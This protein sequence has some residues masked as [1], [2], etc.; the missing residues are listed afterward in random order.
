MRV[1][2]LS[3]LTM[4]STPLR[5]GAG[6]D[7]ATLLSILNAARESGDLQNVVDIVHGLQKQLDECTAELKALRESLL[8]PTKPK[9][10]RRVMSPPKGSPETPSG[11]PRPK[12]PFEAVSDMPTNPDAL[13]AALDSDAPGPATRSRAQSVRQALMRGAGE[14]AGADPDNAD[15]GGPSSSGAGGSNDPF[16][17]PSPARRRE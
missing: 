3:G 1:P 15:G 16:K 7:D 6:I 4:S 13:N 14:G 8:T 2:D 11:P 12:A 9:G 5:I 10:K 17:T